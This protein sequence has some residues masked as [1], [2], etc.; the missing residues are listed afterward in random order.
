M[1]VEV[2]VCNFSTGD[3]IRQQVE[4]M[5]EAFDMIG[6]MTRLARNLDSAKFPSLLPKLR[7]QVLMNVARFLTGGEFSDATREVYIQLA[8][9]SERSTTTRSVELVAGFLAADALDAAIADPA[10]WPEFDAVSDD[11]KHIVTG[12]E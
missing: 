5:A 11:L 4:T 9:K 10:R 6:E 8:A 7:D 3:V 1:S 12:A 2:I